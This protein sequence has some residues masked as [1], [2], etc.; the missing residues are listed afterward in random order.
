M[1]ITLNTVSGLGNAK[2]NSLCSQH[3]GQAASCEASPRAGAAASR[4]ESSLRRPRLPR[5]EPEQ[6]WP[7]GG[8]GP[9]LPE[10]SRCELLKN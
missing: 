7:L 10:L 5:G 6:G 2:A 9:R 3:P 8:R 4:G 1:I